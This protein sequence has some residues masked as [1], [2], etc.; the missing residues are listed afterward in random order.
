[1]RL[2]INLKKA[3]K[4]PPPKLNEFSD[5]ACDYS[6]KARAIASV[7]IAITFIVLD[8]IF[9]FGL[10]VNVYIALAIFEA[11]INQPFKFLRKLFKAKDKLLL[12]TNLIDIIVI[13]IA[14]YFAGGITF[15]FSGFLYLIV[16]A[17]NGI[18]TG[19]A[20]AFLLAVASS[21]AVSTLF[22]LEK[23]GIKYTTPFTLSIPEVIQIVLLASY[24]LIFMLF[25][26]LVHIPSKKL[27]TEVEERKKIEDKLTRQ[28]LAVE[29]LYNLTNLIFRT[30]TT[31]E[32]YRQVV[33][34]IV[35]IL[36][37]DRASILTIDPDGVMRF[38]AWIG[39]S[40][41]Y[42]KAVEGH[43]PW[44][45]D[46][47]NPQPI[48]IA[49]VREDKTLDENLKKVIL[50]EG[51]EAIA[52]VPLVYE[53]KLF[54]KFMLYY[55]Q[56]H[57]FTY[58][59]I[60]LAQTVAIQISLTLWKKLTEI[61]LLN[62]K[63]KFEKIIS[64][65][66]E[67]T[68]E[69]DI[70][71]NETI[72]EGDVETIFGVSKDDINLGKY[73]W[74]D[75]IHPDDIGALTLKI[76]DALE[77]NLSVFEAEYRIKTRDG[78]VKYC[79][80]YAYIT[81][82]EKGKAIKT[83]GII[84][85][86]SQIK[87]AEQKL[88]KREQVLKAINYSAGVLLKTINW[89]SEIDNLL[90]E[91]GKALE[92]SSVSIFKN[93]QNA[94]LITGLAF[95]WYSSDLMRK[96]EDVQLQNISY[97]LAGFDRWVN[98]LAN[99]GLIYGVVKDMPFR[100]YLF[101]SILGVKSIAVAPIFVGGKWWGFV[102]FNDC[103]NE[104]TWEIMEIDAIKT[105]ADILG[106]AIQRSETEKFLRK[107]EQK[108]RKLFEDSKDPIYISTPEGRLLDVNQAFVE[109]FG[110]SSKEEILKVD[111]ATELYQNPE[112]R[113]KNLE[114]VE[115]QGYVKDYELHLKTKDGK[116]LIVYDTATPIY[117]ENGNIIAYQGILRDVTRVKTLE[118]QLIHS[119]KMEALGKLSAQLAHD[120]NNALTVILGNT[121]LARRLL[122]QDIEK[123]KE[124]LN[125]VEQTIRKTADFTK[126]F[127]IFSREQPTEM[128]V[129]D[130][131]TVVN[132][133]AKVML[134]ALRENI[135]MELILAPKLPN[136]KVDPALINQLLL[137]LI[138]NA[139]E[140][141]PDAGKIIVETYHR[142]IDE[143]YCKFNIEAKP[144]E[145][146]VLSV[147]DTGVGIDKSIINKIFE[148]FF[149]TKQ[150]G[151][152]L[153]LSIVYGI[154]KAHNGFINVYSEV[155][156]GTT[157]R[158]YLPAVHEEEQEEQAKIE[159]PAEI[160][161]GNETILVAEDEEK[162]RATVYDILTGLG[163][164]VY[165]AGN[166][167]EAVE[168][169]R[170]KSEEI[171]LVLLDIVMPILSGYDAMKEIVKIKP[172][173]K[174]IFA[175]GYSLNGLNV[176]VEGFDLIQKPYSY[177]TIAIKVREVLDRKV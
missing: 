98:V 172:G 73:R 5:F 173:V 112:D 96:V 46:E 92:V 95:K 99:H 128:K 130:L 162:L 38:K 141:I 8:R 133:F 7:S 102:S 160:R 3:M 120:I 153:G 89:E 158:V 109:L 53:G 68:Y 44:K 148:P 49:N 31:E 131:N 48:L 122:T 139:Q 78:R 24:I 57:E 42:R 21:I 138:L 50:T 174:I 71:K 100:E 20:R 159:K 123:A 166:G 10:P 169:F 144:G 72:W 175:T 149:T 104:K 154:V 103:E 22:L 30:E 17:F 85:D 33:S 163:Y 177:E 91:I 77:G 37:V 69:W 145:Y 43:S 94:D 88:L 28:L 140:A 87:E 35:K 45:P 65:T 111:I 84:F 59:E 157:F 106:I 15:L 11:L 60:S 75:F 26:S 66:K 32:F 58:D 47:A 4:Q 16:I 127:L 125:E 170:E 12:A 142:V 2:K 63:S 167:L 118:Q 51:I 113:K 76:K 74:R 137:N 155:G 39:L 119:Q 40:E 105:F 132:D 9:K 81:R 143:E 67:V 126:K 55:N 117:D 110:Y 124:K 168:I 171:D 64:A 93:Q 36:K 34:E 6:V 27:I 146:V 13:S 147:T 14:V 156:Q 23:F 107:S 86:I 18:I 29:S 56:P 54:G 115:K 165:T 136:V 83:F 90:G 121:Q 161:G 134:K 108:Y 129:I 164:K 70:E 52:F 114:A 101:L 25:A 82:D 152:G 135:K 62:W 41:N 116:K 79:L 1:M 176:N 150:G 19:S 80:D 61:D 97:K 151:T